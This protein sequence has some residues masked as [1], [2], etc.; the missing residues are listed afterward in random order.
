MAPEDEN[1]QGILGPKGLGFRVYPSGHILD[2]EVHQR[3]VEGV[4]FTLVPLTSRSSFYFGL[5]GGLGLSA[6]V[7]KYH[8]LLPILFQT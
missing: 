5:F 8:M 3:R 7:P 4:G 2:L 1:L 6:R